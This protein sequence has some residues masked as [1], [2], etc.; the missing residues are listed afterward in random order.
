MK[1]LLVAQKHTFREQPHRA[2]DKNGC[3]QISGGALT[4]T[5]G[6]QKPADARAE[7]HMGQDETHVLAAPTPNEPSIELKFENH[8]R[9]IMGSD[10]II[11]VNR[12]EFLCITS[13]TETVESAGINQVTSK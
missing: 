7:K 1:M 11:H 4:N 12:E 2:P 8:C 6:G 13:K 9:D 3:G 10:V 5:E